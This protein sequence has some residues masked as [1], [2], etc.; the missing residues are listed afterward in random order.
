MARAARQ[1][2]Q[3][4][5]SSVRFSGRRN[6]VVAANTGE[7][8]ATQRSVAIQSTPITQDGHSA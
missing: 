3:T 6:I 2:A 7:P 4:D 8:G 5:G 1:T